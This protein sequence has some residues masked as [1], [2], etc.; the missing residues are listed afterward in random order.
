MTPFKLR[1]D[2]LCHDVY[3]DK[4]VVELHIIDKYPMTIHRCD[5]PADGARWARKWLEDRG[6]EWTC[7]IDLHQ[8]SNHKHITLH[9]RP[10]EVHS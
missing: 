7:D 2:W 3:G 9:P 5:S 4:V 6:F 10:A 8:R 1:V